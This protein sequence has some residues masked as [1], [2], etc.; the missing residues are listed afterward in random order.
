MLFDC[1]QRYGCLGHYIVSYDLKY[2][3][4]NCF[5][6]NIWYYL[7]LGVY[8]FNLLF[9]SC[10]CERYFYILSSIIFLGVFVSIVLW[11]CC[12]LVS[13]TQSLI[14]VVL[15]NI[16]VWQYQCWCILV[17]YLLGFCCCSQYLG[18][19]VV[20]CFLVWFNFR[21]FSLSVDWNI[22]V[23]K[24]VLLAPNV[25]LLSISLIFWIVGSCWVYHIIWTVYR[26]ILCYLWS[27]IFCYNYVRI[28]LPM[29]SFE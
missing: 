6:W 20:C 16:I 21:M 8:L 18:S 1:R 29:P 2:L 27:T 23:V 14:R 11:C 15:D 9:L 7:G 3:L 28:R 25:L 26:L 22:F 24:Y 13:L 4:S 19:V 10:W 17:D 12:W 5:L